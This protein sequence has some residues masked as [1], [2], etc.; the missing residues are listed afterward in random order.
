[1]LI[2][3]MRISDNWYTSVIGTLHYLSIS[4]GLFI[5]GALFM[6]KKAALAEN[7]WGTYMRGGVFTRHYSIYSM[8]GGMH[9]SLK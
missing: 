9:V 1:M 3:D 7:G 5:I 6:R 4:W 8:E 2:I